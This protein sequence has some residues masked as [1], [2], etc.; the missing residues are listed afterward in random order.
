MAKK[1]YKVPKIF[2]EVYPE[3]FVN[4]VTKKPLKGEESAFD[5]LLMSDHKKMWEFFNKMTAVGKSK[6]S[7]IRDYEQMIKDPVTLSA[8]EM[9][10]EDTFQLSEQGDSVKFYVKNKKIG[11]M[12]QEFLDRIRIEERIE[13]W[14]FSVP[15]YGEMPVLVRGV[16]D[17]GIVS[18]M[19][20]IH[21]LDF[22][23][24]D[25]GS[26]YGFMTEYEKD[27]KGNMLILPPWEAVHF[28]YKKSRIR[29]RLTD[30]IV[31][32]VDGKK[33]YLENIEVEGCL[34]GV[35][36]IQKNLRLVEDSM[37]MARLDRAPLKRVFY[38]DVGDATPE[39]KVQIMKDFKA[40]Y[41][42]EVKFDS[43]DYYD[44]KSNPL[45]FGQELF[46]PISEGLKGIDV[47][48]YGGKTDVSHI[49]DIEY[50][51]NKYFAGL[52]IPKAFLGL[53][54]D[55][56]GSLG[57][58][59]LVRMEIRYARSVKANR[60][61]VLNGLF[62]LAQIDLGYR[63]IAVTSKDLQ[64]YGNYISS[65]EEEDMI[66]SISDRSRVASDFMRMFKDLGIEI[67]DNNKEYIVRLIVHDLMHMTNVDLD[68]L[69]NAVKSDDDVKDEM[70]KFI[71][72][73]LGSFNNASGVTY[74]D[75]SLETW[76]N[77]DRWVRRFST[78]FRDDIKGV[79]GFGSD[80]DHDN[81][82][83]IK[84]IEDIK[85]DASKRMRLKIPKHISNKEGDNAK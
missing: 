82:S 84:R 56:P 29:E 77:K 67:N 14:A 45:A 69:L 44:S 23:R 52:K 37:V 66:N 38:I 60:R 9:L 22:H 63:G 85:N 83:D 43:N 36:Y 46:I 8:V 51:R 72:E 26:L 15:F 20:S 73:S 79:R 11:S 16:P 35:R 81:N 70:R 55:L 19:D 75:S 21:P 25:A 1:E 71:S 61:A 34:E 30:R 24:I 54:E 12:V 57:E 41:K 4:P 80:L 49:V 6:L 48:E 18:I 31:V 27:D 64:F 50:L 2:K 32:E 59:A 47:E 62:R 42:R 3:A 58:S 39:Q 5:S 76:V 40:N 65:A 68:Q 10:A 78:L 53:E 17:E 13:D 7:K 28:I 74:S 33:V